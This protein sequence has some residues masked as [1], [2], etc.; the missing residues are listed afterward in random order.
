LTGT[1]DWIGTTRGDLTSGDPGRVARGAFSVYMN[2]GLAAAVPEERA[3][4][5]AC[6]QMDRVG[7]ALEKS[8]V[9]HRATSWVVDDPAAQHF[10]T[11]GRDG[12]T[13]DL[14]QLPGEVNGEPG[15]FEWMVDRTGGRPVITHQRF[16]RG[17][18]VTGVPN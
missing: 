7:T 3:G 4:I 14:Y 11:T 17:A 12:V 13:R 9:Y 10:P 16:K 5:E 18:D 8:D 2:V 15:V 1:A 6:S